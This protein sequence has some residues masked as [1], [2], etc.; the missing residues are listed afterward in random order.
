MPKRTSV[1]LRDRT[2]EV[3]GE[4][5]EGETFSGRLN[6]VVDRY[7]EI[8]DLARRTAFPIFTDAELAKMR[9]ACRNWATETAAA[10]TTINSLPARVEDAIQIGVLRA[11][12]ESAPEDANAFLEKVRTLHPVQQLALVEWIEAERR[13]A[14]ALN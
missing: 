14:A 3:M 7:G 1:Y 10:S 2:L 8:I 4:V 9:E 5:P 13:D 6:A 12:R 11:W